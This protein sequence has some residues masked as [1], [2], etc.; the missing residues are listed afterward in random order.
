MQDEQGFGRIGGRR[1][2]HGRDRTHHDGLVMPLGIGFL[3]ACEAE[4]RQR[5]QEGGDRREETG[6]AHPGR[7]SEE[8]QQHEGQGQG[9]ENQQQD[10]PG[11]G[12]HPVSDFPDP[13]LQDELRDLVDAVLGHRPG[14]FQVVADIR[15]GRI[16]PE[17][18]LV[19]Q[20]GL[21]SFPCLEI[22]VSE[23]VIQFLG[24]EP[25]GSHVGPVL[26]GFR[27]LSG[28]IGLHTGRPQRIRITFSRLRSQRKGQQQGDHRSGRSRGNTFLHGR[29]D[30]GNDG[31]GLLVMGVHRL[32]A[33]VRRIAGVFAGVQ[34]VRKGFHRRLGDTAG[35]ERFG[36][37]L[38]ALVGHVHRELVG[39]EADEGPVQFLIEGRIK[40]LVQEIAGQFQPLQR[41]AR[42]LPVAGAH[43]IGPAG[44]QF[45][46]G[47]PDRS[48]SQDQEGRQAPEERFPDKEALVFRQG[49][50][51]LDETDVFAQVLHPLPVH[52]ERSGPVLDGLGS[53]AGA[54]R[55]G[56]PQGVRGCRGIP[57]SFHVIIGEA[58]RRKG[59]RSR[60]ARNERILE[61]LGTV[62]PA[63]VGRTRGL[64]VVSLEVRR[65]R[66]LGGF[67]QRD[68][69]LARHRD[70]QRRRIMRPQR[71]LADP[72]RHA[73]LAHGAGEAG[74]SAAR[75]GGHLDADRRGHHPLALGHIVILEKIVEDGAG[76]G[77]L[78]PYIHQA[79]DFG[80]VDG[81]RSRLLRDEH[82]PAE[83]RRI[84]HL[85]PHLL[86]L[87]FDI[88]GSIHLLTPETVELRELR[89][90][91][92]G[93]VRP[94]VDLEGRRDGFAYDGLP[95][96]QVQPHEDLAGIL[97]DR[98]PRLPR[99]TGS[100][101]GGASGASLGCGSLIPPF[102]DGHLCGAGMD[103]RPFHRRRGGCQLERTGLLRLEDIGIRG[104]GSLR[105]FPVHDG[106]AGRGPL[107]RAPDKGEIVPGTP[108]EIGRGMFS[109]HDEDD[110]EPL[111]QFHDIVYF[112]PDGLRPPGKGHHK[113]RKGSHPSFHRLTN[114]FLSGG[115]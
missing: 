110:I 91:K 78:G 24:T 82:P 99:R 20:D 19:V 51:R 54:P 75:Q 23:V 45:P 96:A 90:F 86:T 48:G 5:Q 43:D 68:I 79:H 94:L 44:G 71:I 31:D 107:L 55:D 46:Q 39:D 41:L 69:A 89:I 70:D 28:R 105:R 104:L 18:A 95:L 3:A 50:L 35:G 22:S 27:P 11:I 32:M 85:V 115:T 15:I 113:R 66:D 21:G 12:R 67:H 92:T 63:L 53:S 7:R 29:I 109:V 83:D 62:G 64:H 76:L 103:L 16:Q 101:S 93:Q 14:E 37:V 111:T 100:V 49:S 57:V 106:N 97:G 36:N 88:L 112:H 81:E 74:R 52:G 87:E 80:R 59:K 73:I 30:G 108:L 61:G 84:E 2:G 4:S 56:K 34:Q 17:G 6:P 1:A 58:D 114:S 9:Q 47:Q 65:E 102:Y 33:G 40:I 13:G 26:E 72:G 8:E 98:L 38:L 25:G 77:T 42:R 10:G 60:A